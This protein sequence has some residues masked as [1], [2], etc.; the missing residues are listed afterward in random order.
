MI[1]IAL[2]GAGFI[3]DYHL[4]GMAGVDGAQAE[5]HRQPQPRKRDAAGGAAW[6]RRCVG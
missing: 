3:A 4:G 2:V 1:G 5:T 6:R